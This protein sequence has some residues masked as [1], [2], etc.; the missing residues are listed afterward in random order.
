MVKKL[1]KN[2]KIKKIIILIQF[3]R[4]F[5]KI[6]YTVRPISFKTV[7]RKPQKKIPKNSKQVFLF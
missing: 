6:H 3:C 2:W 1:K 5:Q 7:L 4:N